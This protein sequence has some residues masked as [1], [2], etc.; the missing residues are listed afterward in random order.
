LFLAE[1]CIGAFDDRT[2]PDRTGQDGDRQDDCFQN[3][4]VLPSKRVGKYE[5]PRFDLKD[6]MQASN[7]QV[8]RLIQYVNPV[9]TQEFF[10]TA[11]SL[12]KQQG[13]LIF[14][15]AL[16]HMSGFSQLPPNRSLLTCKPVCVSEN[17]IRPCNLYSATFF[18]WLSS[19][20]GLLASH[21]GVQ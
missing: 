9:S 7:L 17:L 10:A 1:S 14:A 20:S 4:H 5:T 15:A 18:P 3:Y 19:P 16:A 2:R 8:I 11:Q 6:V 21:N 13:A 12:L